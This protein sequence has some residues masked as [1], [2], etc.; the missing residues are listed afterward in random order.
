[1]SRLKVGRPAALACLVLAFAVHLSL[2]ESLGSGRLNPLF[3]DSTHRKGQAVDFFTV[4]WGSLQ[5]LRGGSLYQY[6]LPHGPSAADPH[7]PPYAYS[8]FRY[9]PGFAFSIGRLL[10]LLKPWSA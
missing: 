6:Q 3:D 7:E 2:L 5:G 8:N 1:M 10:T 4:Y 9:F